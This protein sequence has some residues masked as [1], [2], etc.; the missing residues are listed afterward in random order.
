MTLL[1]IIFDHGNW[2]KWLK[3]GE[4]QMS[5]LSSAR[6]RSRTQGMPGQS[7]SPG[8][9]MEQLITETISRHRKDKITSWVVSL[10]SLIN[11]YDEKMTGQAD[12]GVVY[13]GFSKAFDTVSR[14]IL[15]KKLL[16]Y[17]LDEQTVRW[18]EN[19]LKGHALRV[20]ISDTKS[21]WRP[22]TTG[23]PQALI[24][25]PV[26]FNIWMMR[27]SCLDSASLQMTPNWEKWLIHQKIVL[28]CRGTLIGWRNGLTQTSGSSKKASAKPLGR[29]NPTHQY[30]W[31]ATYL[32][33]HLTEQVLGLPVDP[34]L[35]KSQQ[36]T[37][38]AL[39]KVWPAAGGRWFW[40]YCWGCT[41][42][43]L[44]VPQ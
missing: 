10:P 37:L 40:S 1:L 36:C 12:E 38:T 15:I 20:V 27:Q 41:W 24:L 29:S 5:L 17:G 19:W 23:V 39:A 33:R 6:A 14:K 18:T 25:S 30:M 28:P 35:N 44:G 4:K 7:V 3:T 31:G 2:E 8:K 11:F 22:V 16:V 43:V 32:E 21:G 34:N 26:L 9:V 42:P 13:V